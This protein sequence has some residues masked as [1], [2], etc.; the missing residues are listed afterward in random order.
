[1]GKLFI[2]QPAASQD[3]DG[4]WTLWTSV[5]NPSA[6]TSHCWKIPGM[7][8]SLP[9][10]LWP[11]QLHLPWSQEGWGTLLFPAGLAWHLAISIMPVSRVSVL[12][13]ISSLVA[14]SPSQAS[15]D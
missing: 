4:L 14:G 1:M 10:A 5:F 3:S 13:L 15:H 8:N 11:F 6:P 7:C 12:A 9:S 2:A